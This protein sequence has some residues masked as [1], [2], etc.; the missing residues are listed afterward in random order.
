MR[1]LAA[2]CLLVAAVALMGLAATDKPAFRLLLTFLYDADPA[3][4]TPYVQF[5]IGGITRTIEPASMRRESGSCGP[6]SM[7]SLGAC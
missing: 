7:I 5:Q 4:K 6:G 2:C 3:T 1:I